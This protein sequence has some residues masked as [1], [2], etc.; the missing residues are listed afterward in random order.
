[1]FT[2]VLFADYLFDLPAAADDEVCIPAVQTDPPRIIEVH[3]AADSDDKPVP[4]A[5]K[6][7]RKTC[8]GAEAV[9]N[10]CSQ[11]P[12]QLFQGSDS[13]RDV[14]NF[15]DPAVCGADPQL[16]DMQSFKVKCGIAEVKNRDGHVIQRRKK[17]CRLHAH[18]LETALVQHRHHQH[19]ID[20]LI[21][22]K[23]R[24]AHPIFI[25]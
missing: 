20:F 19:Q 14:Q 16:L 18:S 12:L 7:V 21:F 9:G 13:P 22:R 8:G 11:L 2:A 5:G 17:S 4:R 1:M 3:I 10:L 24:S 15:R 6:A 25:P 23:F